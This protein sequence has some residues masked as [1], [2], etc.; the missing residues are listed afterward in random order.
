VANKTGI[1]QQRNEVG[2]HCLHNFPQT[3]ISQNQTIRNVNKNSDVQVVPNVI[4]NGLLVMPKNIAEI[5]QS[6]QFAQLKSSNRTDRKEST[7]SSNWLTDY[8][9]KNN[10]TERNHV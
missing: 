5:S 1:A 8:K 7:F 10:L 6:N 4:V 3:S 9:A 2:N